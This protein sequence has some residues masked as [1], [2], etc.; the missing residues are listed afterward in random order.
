MGGHFKS[1]LCTILQKNTFPN[2]TCKL[3]LKCLIMLLVAVPIKL[4]LRVLKCINKA[5]ILKLFRSF[6]AA[7]PL[8]IVMSLWNH[9]VH[10]R[11]FGRIYLRL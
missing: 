10:L 11:F 4:L 6:G 8:V 7:L 5:I 1:I 3:A 2:T 9:L